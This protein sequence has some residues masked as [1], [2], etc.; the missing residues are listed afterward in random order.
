M[1]RTNSVKYIQDEKETFKTALAENE[2][3]R[4]R[5]QRM[6]AMIK[7]V[8]EIPD[9]EVAYEG[10]LEHIFSAAPVNDETDLVER[11]DVNFVSQNDMYSFLSE[12][13]KRKIAPFYE[14]LYEMKKVIMF[15]PYLERTVIRQMRSSAVEACPYV[16]L[17]NWEMVIR[18]IVFLYTFLDRAPP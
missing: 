2:V 16:G 9:E 13:E 7:K 3:P 12:Q 17:A 6:A 1:S 8:I 5:K 14:N 4:E 18:R 11:F 15:L 10:F